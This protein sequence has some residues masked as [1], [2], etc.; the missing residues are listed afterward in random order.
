M[1]HIYFLF[2]RK[3]SVDR[4]T[5]HRHYLEIHPLQGGRPYHAGPTP[6]LPRYIQNHRLHSLGGDSTFDG[7]SEIWS[8]GALV[9]GPG[10]GGAKQGLSAR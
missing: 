7:L 10:G 6:T 3:P 8:S 2:A 5:F 1:T 4:R 9:G